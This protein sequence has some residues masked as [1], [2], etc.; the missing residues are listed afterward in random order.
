M[1]F[2][3]FQP[4]RWVMSAGLLA[5][6]FLMGGAVEHGAH[7]LEP[8]SA[9]ESDQ[10]KEARFWEQLT[11]L[12]MPVQMPTMTDHRAFMLPSG[13]VMALHFDNM[14]I[15][16]AENLNWVALGIPGVYCKADQERVQAAYGPGFTHFHDMQNDIHGGAPGAQGVWFVHTAVRDFQAP[17]GAVSQGIDNKF[18]ITPAP[19]C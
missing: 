5:A 17:W 3:S 19:T 14:N 16:Q 4:R 6:G 2:V 10:A 12:Y 18:M 15:D 9:Q 13:V 11:S 8:A 7:L 1:R